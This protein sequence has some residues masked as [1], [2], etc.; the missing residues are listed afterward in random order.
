MPP[1][2]MFGE[3]DSVVSIPKLVISVSIFIHMSGIS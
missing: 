2:R 3:S 1:Y